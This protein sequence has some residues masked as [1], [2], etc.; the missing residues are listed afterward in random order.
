MAENYRPISLT[1]IVCKI[2]ESF[3]CKAIV[4]HLNEHKL[5]R[6]SQHG[7][8]AHRSC[9]TNLLEYLE[10]VTDLLD[11]GHNVDV[12]YLDFSKALDKALDFF[13]SSAASRSSK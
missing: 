4:A 6:S 3:V 13:R 12:F 1:S 7:F 8:V 9:L 5:L 11:K 2:L 10:S